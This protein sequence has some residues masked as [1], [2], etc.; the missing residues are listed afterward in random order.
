MNNL[1]KRHGSSKRTLERYI[2][3]ITRS[4]KKICLEVLSPVKTLK[5]TK[6][7]IE[8]I[9][10]EVLH[11]PD[12]CVVNNNISKEPDVIKIDN[13]CTKISERSFDGTPFQENSQ[14]AENFEFC[15]SLDLF[16]KNNCLENKLIENLTSWSLTHNISANAISALLI[17]L[18][19]FGLTFLPKDARTLKKTP[20][21]I[22]T[23]DVEPGSY[24]HFGVRNFL[25]RL[26]NHNLKV[27]SVLTLNI[28]IDG[29]PF[30]KSSKGSF[31]PILG[32]FKEFPLMNPFVIG[33]YFHESFKP[34]NPKVFL[35]DFIEEMKEFEKGKV[36]DTIINMGIFVFDAVASAYIRGVV[37][38]NAYKSCPKCTTTGSYHGRMCYPSISCDLRSNED[39]RQRK[40]PDHHN[41][42]FQNP[43]SGPI[44]DLN[45]DVIK[46]CPTDY[47][48]LILLG[49]VKKFL[50]I[51]LK[52][53]S[54]PK[55]GL[56]RMKLDKIKMEN[57]FNATA[58]AL[59]NQPSDFVRKIRSIE[60]I[61]FFK[62]SELRTFLCYHGIVVLKHNIHEE[63]YY[64]FLLLHCAVRI[65]MS[66]L[67]IR[68]LLPLA[69]KLFIAFIKMFI[70]QFGEGMVSY[71]IHNLQHVVEDVKLHGPLDSFSAFEYENHLG[72]LKKY[73]KSGKHPLQEM[74]LRVLEN[75]DFTIKNLKEKLSSPQVYPKFSSSKIQLSS[76]VTLSK[77][78]K[79]C[80]FLSKDKKI[81]RFEKIEIEDGIPKIIAKCIKETS[82]F[83]TVPIKSSILDIYY[84]D[85]LLGDCQQMH[86]NDISEK[87]FCI[88]D[89]NGKKVFIPLIHSTCS[90]L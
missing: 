76:N 34:Y 51:V 58:L 47:M 39:F 59:Y 86:I 80:W 89:L 52:K 63:F 4:S 15:N 14:P 20:K 35:K 29:L 50:K 60:H 6:E 2:E 81:C 77:D 28:N 48:H 11:P 33:L 65:C 30:S 24:W 49:V 13:M 87:M 44:E 84:S 69:K 42:N 53:M 41:K 21:E 25:Q 46:S 12:P 36:F 56:L 26:K 79:N 38:H 22:V 17:I 3:D 19:N 40:D 16:E 75:M 66:Q 23:R 68:K 83:F 61:H 88:P 1:P 10:V 32:K 73:I 31:W 9:S 7:K 54:F 90:K 8:I 67:L 72:V 71:N 78:N 85:G 82:D 64:C 70:K 5:P 62:A 57:I 55:N 37:G 45:I 18:I 27:P 43:N 74:S